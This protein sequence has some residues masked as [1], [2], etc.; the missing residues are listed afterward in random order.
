MFLVT[1]VISGLF[2][3]LF[4]RG[5]VVLLRSHEYRAGGT[6]LILHWNLATP[7]TGTLTGWGSTSNLRSIPENR[8]DTTVNKNRQYIH[9]SIPFVLCSWQVIVQAG[10]SWH[11]E[12]CNAFFLCVFLPYPHYKQNKC[13]FW[14]F[15]PLTWSIHSQI[16]DSENCL[17]S[18]WFCFLRST[19]TLFG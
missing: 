5:S 4:S 2:Y 17:I 12:I 16:H 1:M 11:F 18:F 13:R 8:Q 15:L 14:D 3:L 9:L 6:A 19:K 10:Q 7:P